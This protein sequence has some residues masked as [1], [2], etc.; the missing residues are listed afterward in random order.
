MSTPRHRCKHRNYTV[1]VI[2]EDAARLP[3]T[4]PFTGRDRNDVEA[5]AKYRGF[6][7][8]RTC[9]DCGAQL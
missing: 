4:S 5:W 9:D 6:K 2:V 1:E 7:T 3:R 8:R